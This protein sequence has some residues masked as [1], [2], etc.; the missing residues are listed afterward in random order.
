VNFGPPDHNVEACVFRSDARSL[1][2]SHGQLFS[3]L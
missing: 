1:Y 3:E 2:G